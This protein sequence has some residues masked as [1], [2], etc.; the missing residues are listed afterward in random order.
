MCLINYYLAGS[1]WGHTKV[2]GGECHSMHLGSPFPTPQ[3]VDEHVHYSIHALWVRVSTQC[4]RCMHMDFHQKEAWHHQS[5]MWWCSD[6]VGVFQMMTFM[7][8][9]K[10]YKR[11][12]AEEGGGSKFQFH[13]VKI[14]TP[15]VL[16]CIPALG[17]PG[18]SI[19]R[20][21]I[22]CL[23]YCFITVMWL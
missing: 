21:K 9:L 18:I 2:P 5:I 14:H 13:R 11:K 16:R 8:V 10:G 12:N 15:R 17:L 19:K 4:T 6:D 7:L 3:K 23:V 20:R 22:M 1:T